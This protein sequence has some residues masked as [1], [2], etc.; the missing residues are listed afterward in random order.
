[1]LLLATRCQLSREAV[2]RGTGIGQR[3]RLGRLTRADQRLHVLVHVPDVDVHSSYYPPIAEPERDELAVGRVTAE[4]DLVPSPVRT[5][6]I[7]RR[8][9][10]DTGQPGLTLTNC[11]FHALAVE[12]TAVVCGMNLAIM[13]GLV[14]GLPRLHL[15]AVIEPADGRCCVRLAART[16]AH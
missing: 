15:T 8:A 13:E 12:H 16:T 10:A 7:P 9:D 5:R 2:K 6:S 1:L 14:A 4:H 3:G 11:P